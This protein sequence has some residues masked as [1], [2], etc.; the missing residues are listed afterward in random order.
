MLRRNFLPTLAAPLLAKEQRP[1]IILILADDMGFS[2]LGCYGGE[3]PTPNLDALAKGG[4]RFSQF[5][6]SARCCPTRSSLLTGHYPHQTSIGHMV[7]NGRELPG[8]RGDLSSKTL[9]IGEVLRKSGYQTRMSGKWHVTPV[10]KSQHNWPNQRG[11]EKFFGTIHGAGSF[12]AP[13]TLVEDNETLEPGKDFYYTDA[14]ANKSVDYIRECTASTKPFF[15][16][17]AFTAPHWPMHAYADD[18]ARHRN[19]YRKGWDQLR[20]DRHKRQVEL[21]IVDAKW[22]VSPRGEKIAA[23]ADTPDKDWQIERMAAY[24]A[25]LERMDQGIGRMVQALKEANALDNTLICFLSDNGGCAEELGRQMKA[26]HV[27][28]KTRTG[29]PVYPGNDPAR[30]PGPENTYQSYGLGWANASNTPFRLYKHWVHEGGISTPFIAH[31]P[32]RIQQAGSITHQPGHIVDCMATFVDLSG[33]KYANEGLS[34]MPVLKGKD[35]LSK[36]SLFW[37]HEGNRAARQGRHKLVSKYPGNW[38]LY[39]LEADRTEVND[40]AASQ[41]KLVASLAASYQT[42]ASRVGA[43]AWDKVQAAPKTPL[44]LD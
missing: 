13:T 6:N 38:E 1:N 18:I 28:T 20:L 5:Y 33:G 37:E 25:M 26:R 23:W 29:E 34:L 30:M 40:L 44:L 41:P 19:T 17:T 3:I 11:F 27:P 10:S 8:Y 4:I 16:Y 43:E 14:I 9:T 7:D 39:D 42:W 22:P 12:Y 31:L 32:G 35:V 2:D 21:G 24:A 36:R 15:L